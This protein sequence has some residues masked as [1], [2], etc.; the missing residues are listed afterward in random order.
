MLMIKKKTH[1]Q[2]IRLNNAGAT[3]TLKNT[4]Q[5]G[6]G[7]LLWSIILFIYSNTID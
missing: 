4:F 3:D 5:F 6:I 2:N 7:P 1:T